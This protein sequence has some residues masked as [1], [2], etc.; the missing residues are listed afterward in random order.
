MGLGIATLGYGFLLTQWAGGGIIAAPVLAYG[1]YL[2]SRTNKRFLAAAVS[3]LL[4]LPYSVLLLLDLFARLEVFSFNT[5]NQDAVYYRIMHSLFLLAWI[6][7]SYYYLT[8]IK[9]IAEDN[10]SKKLRS[11]ASNRH[12]LTQ[13]ILIGSFCLIIFENIITPEIP[14]FFFVMQYVI[15][16]INVLFL[17]TCFIL[18]TTERQYERDKRKIAK[19][20]DKRRKKDK[21]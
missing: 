5:F 10:N 16:I 19:E 6:S 1:F 4:M 14:A 11:K 13:I 8:A 17:H 2:A 20:E 3:A 7:M 21:D 15:I 12:Y 18:I 9:Q